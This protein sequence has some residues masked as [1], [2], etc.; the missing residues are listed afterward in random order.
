M[1]VFDQIL[2][3]R[4]VNFGRER[5]RQGTAA[6]WAHADL[7]ESSHRKC[8]LSRPSLTLKELTLP[9]RVLKA[10]N[11]KTGKPSFPDFKKQKHL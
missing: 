8:P 5:S 10:T 9:S 4:N 11:F 3:F 7:P 6:I 2:I 1:D